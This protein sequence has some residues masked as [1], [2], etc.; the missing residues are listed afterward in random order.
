M[1]T[2]AKEKT[3]IKIK[4]TEK[5]KTQKFNSNKRIK[6]NEVKKKTLAKHIYVARSWFL[7]GNDLPRFE[8]VKLGQK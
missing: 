7:A 6:N 8:N 4:K 2:K 3:E 1:E 5:E